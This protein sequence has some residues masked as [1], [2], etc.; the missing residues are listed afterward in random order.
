MLPL[1]MELWRVYVLLKDLKGIE[2]FPG[3]ERGIKGSFLPHL[4]FS[5]HNN[6][7]S[8]HCKLL[9]NVFSK[10]SILQRMCVDLVGFFK[11]HFG[12]ELKSLQHLEKIFNNLSV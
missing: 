8:L 11:N 2:T 1:E 10:T 3:R 6:I 5:Y 9:W 12:K 7:T 4:L